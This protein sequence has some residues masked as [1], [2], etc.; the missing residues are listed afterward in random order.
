MSPEISERS[1]ISA[2][3]TREH[4]RLL[5]YVRKHWDD[6]G[7]AGAEDILQ[8]VALNLF[9]KVDFSSP[10]ENLLAYTYRA[11]RNRIIDLRRKKSHQSIEAYDDPEGENLLLRKMASDEIDQESVAERE[12][13]IRLMMKKLEDLPEDQREVLVATE[14]EGCTFEELSRKWGIPLGTLLSRK[15]RAMGKLHRMLADPYENKTKK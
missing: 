11:L 9:I 10:I 8:D 13:L 4:D 6:D 1:R 12:H 7:T 3:I 2:F 15:H 14:L 5:G